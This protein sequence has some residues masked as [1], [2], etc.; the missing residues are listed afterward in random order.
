MTRQAPMM[1]KS[2]AVISKPRNCKVVCVE[3]CKSR[4]SATMANTTHS[5][6]VGVMRGTRPRE[7][8]D[9]REEISLM[10]SA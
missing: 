2:G 6:R 1:T 4:I 5:T 8:D 9:D 3:F 10:R 7:L